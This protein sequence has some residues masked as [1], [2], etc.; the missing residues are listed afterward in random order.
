M[1][2]VRRL[3]WQVCFKLTPTPLT[4][5]FAA[6]SHLASVE[7]MARSRLAFPTL[8]YTSLSRL[9][10]MGYNHDRFIQNRRYS[11]YTWNSA[12]EGVYPTQGKCFRPR[13]DLVIIQ[14]CETLTTFFSLRLEYDLDEKMKG[15]SKK[16]TKNPTQPKL[17]QPL[18]PRKG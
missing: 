9:S 12:Q 14:N 4:S 2:A 7:S 17:A 8:P 10:R 1:R 18:F 16:K 5:G 6:I 11:S 3:G 13:L 15:P